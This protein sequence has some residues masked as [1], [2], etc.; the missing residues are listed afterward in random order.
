[1]LPIQKGG[2]A[3]NVLLITAAAP[4]QGSMQVHTDSRRSP[5]AR[6]MPMHGYA[7]VGG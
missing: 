7:C 1:M 3:I 2:G 6:V 4:T 5:Y